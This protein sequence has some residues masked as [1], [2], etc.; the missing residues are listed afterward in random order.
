MLP[1]PT[2]RRFTIAPTIV[3][4]TDASVARSGNSSGSTASVE[5]AALHMP[6]RER[7]GLSTHADHDVPALRRARVF[8]EALENAGAD[9]ARGLE[10]ERRRISGS[11]R[12]L[13]IVFGTVA[14]PMRPRV[15]SA[16]RAAP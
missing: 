2:V 13:S 15:R 8:H 11:G 1:R 7:A 6:E 10:A 9:R 12:S 3:S 5:P 14:T 16:I 4:A